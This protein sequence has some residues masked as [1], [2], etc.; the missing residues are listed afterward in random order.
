MG[1]Q[2]IGN[3]QWVVWRKN[4]KAKEMFVQEKKKSF[5]SVIGN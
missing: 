5:L 4:K 2:N 3:F 1:K